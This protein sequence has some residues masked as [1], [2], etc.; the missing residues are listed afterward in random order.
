MLLLWVS[1][2]KEEPIMNKKGSKHLDL[3]YRNFIENG[4]N[5]NSTRSAI[6]QVI[7]MDKSSVCKEI[8]KH[9][10]YVKF[11]RQGVSNAGTY[12]CVNIASCGYNA[13]CRNECPNRIPIPCKIRDKSKGV[14][15]GC[16]D[17]S[18]CKLTKRFYSAKRAQDEYEYS[19]VDSREGINL[20][21]SELNDIAS[22]IVEPIK[23]GQ[24]VFAVLQAHPEI[25]YCE[26]TIYN[27]ID[28]GAFQAFGLTNIDLRSK[29]KR[30][31]KKDQKLKY[32][33]RVN[34]AFLK[35]RTYDCFE[36]FMKN[37][38]SASVVE[39]DTVYNDVSNG[40]FIQ[41]FMFVS[42]GIMVAVYH[43]KHNAEA[44]VN[45]LRYIKTLLGENLFQSVFQVLLTD[46]GSE[47]SDAI[48]FEELVDHI[49]YCDPMA[50]WQKP[51]VERNHCLLR[52]ICP[53]EKDL[54]KLGLRSQ[55]DLDLIFSHINS[56]AREE[57]HG[58]SPIDEF[59]FY[60]N[61]AETILELLH[62]KHI[63]NDLIILNPSL[64]KK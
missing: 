29:V 56:Y 22:I 38:P 34:K 59:C 25:H 53:K 55:D 41:T 13:F 36:T 30:K 33:K 19:L 44:M 60:H 8:K 14:C 10:Y 35:G 12:D 18:T 39:M 28:L 26:K 15:N 17:L 51:H 6:A 21:Y 5:N 58:K 47:F 40:P 43:K 9:S 27:W 49:F 7:G 23:N 45:G 2:T 52:Y 31:M 11:S 24:S 3:Q 4:L 61:E 62:I 63:E 37:H 50:S 48:A 64:I 54:N 32:K 42:F 57:R 46:R 20:T 1:L 16:K